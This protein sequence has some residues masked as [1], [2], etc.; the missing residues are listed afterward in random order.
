MQLIPVTILFFDVVG[1]SMK[2]DAQCTLPLSAQSLAKTFM[3][4]RPASEPR[5]SCGSKRRGER[6]EERDHRTDKWDGSRADKNSR[7][8]FALSL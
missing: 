1:F 3:F 5:F 8:F 4:L 2:R 6:L 7:F